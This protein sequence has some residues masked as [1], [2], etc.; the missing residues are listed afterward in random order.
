[1]KTTK[2]NIAL[3][4]AAILLSGLVIGQQEMI[5][6]DKTQL[7]ETNN[8]EIVIDDLINPHHNNSEQFKALIYPNPSFTGK[9][10]MTW[11]DDQNVDLIMLMRVGWD[12][13]TEINIEHQ[14][15]IQ[16]DGLLEG[17]YY[18]KFLYNSQLLATQK[19]T[20]IKE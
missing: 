4:F 18:V 7:D 3:L 11:Q 8:T 17:A 1:M 14:K 6:V 13:V 2:I 12:D 5:Q 19:L 20:V 15:E 10:K 9:V 16:I